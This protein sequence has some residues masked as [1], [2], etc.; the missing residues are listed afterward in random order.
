MLSSLCTCVNEDQQSHPMNSDMV[1]DKLKDFFLT[2]GLKIL[3]QNVNGLVKKISVVD[4]LLKGA[5]GNIDIFTITETHFHR[6]I[7]D[8][9]LIS[10]GYVFVRKDTLTSSGGGVGCFI[11]EDLNWQRRTDLG[12]EGIE[13]IWLEIFIRNSKPLL[14]CIL[15]RPHNSSRYLH[16]EFEIIFKDTLSTAVCENKETILLGDLNVDYL[17]E[18]NDEI[19]RIIQIN[20]LKQL[21]KAPT[22][23]TK[24]S[25]TLIDI[26]ATTHAQNI[27]NSMTYMY[28]NSISDHDLVGVA[29]KKN[30]RKFQPRTIRKRNFS[31]YNAA[32]FRNDLDQQ[33]WED[34]FRQQDLNK[35]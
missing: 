14:V 18:T 35:A 1:Y 8:G 23:I 28:A 13:A 16:P 27:S 5:N 9:E 21:I 2:R 25:N 31:R 33:T 4:I 11:R 10:N 22:R 32:A 7:R 20:G 19:K 12:K 15:Y 30:N 29:M 26:I 17:R 34:V 24:E 3:H 6:E